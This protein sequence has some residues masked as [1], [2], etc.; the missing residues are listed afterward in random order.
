[1]CLGTWWAC[2]CLCCVLPARGRGGRCLEFT[3]SS[4]LA[5]A[6]HDSV[7][8]SRPALEVVNQHSSRPWAGLAVPGCTGL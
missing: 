7:W 5:G 3:F 1:M 2:S 8:A 4:H 6:S